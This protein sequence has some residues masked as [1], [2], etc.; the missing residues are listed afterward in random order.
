[1]ESGTQL[2]DEAEVTVRMARDYRF[3][4]GFNSFG[5]ARLVNRLLANNSLVS[6]FWPPWSDGNWPANTMETVS[7]I[8]AL[9]AQHLETWIPRCGVANK[10]NGIEKISGQKGLTGEL[11]KL[12]GRWERYLDEHH[13]LD[14]ATIQNRFLERQ[15]LMI[16][17]FQHVFVDEF[18]DSNPIQFAIHTRWLLNA[19][20]RVTVVGDDDQAIYRFRGSDIECFR[21]LEP[22]CKANSIRFRREDLTT[23]YR[24]TQAIVDFSQRFKSASSL[25]KLSMRKKIGPGPKAPKGK[26]VRLL[27]G[28]WQ[29]VCDAV[30]KE[31]VGFGLNKP[32][33]ATAPRESVAIL[34]FSTS[35]RESKS[36]KSPALALRKTL[37]AVGIRVYNPRNKMAGHSSSPVSMLLGL[38]SYLIDPVTFEP[39]GKNG[40]T[41]MV[42]ASH[43]D[44]A[45]AAVARSAPPTFR[46]NQKHINFQK[47]FLKGEGGDIGSPAP[48]RADIV[49]FL[50]RIRSALVKFPSGKRGRLTVAGLVS[51]LLTFPLFRNAGF[52]VDL[53][54][55]ALFTQLLEANIAP[56]RLT[57]KSLDQPLE[58]SEVKGKIVWDDRFW[59]FLN[60]F[61]AY[62]D[63]N[64]PDDLEVEAFE[65]GAVLMITFHQAKGLEFDHV[66]VAGAGREI[67]IAPALR[68]QLFSGERIP[69]KVGTNGVATSN[70]HTNQ[71]A[72][73][74]REREVYVAITRAK[75]SLT[76]LHDAVH[77]ELY[78]KMN[79]AIQA[80]FKGATEKRHNAQKSVT[81]MEAL[82]PAT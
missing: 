59:S 65:E 28:E 62:L 24:S 45:Y 79:P 25:S 75:Q 22:H 61:G 66:Y 40:R 27:K 5:P 50:D 80:V 21:G 26:P 13:I 11:V 47:K 52:T 74:D 20:T 10:P 42:W 82:C 63:N 67:D 15:S 41:V 36:W 54:R 34:S 58:A 72:A 44:V 7:F 30:A 14:F 51:R 70:A 38:I 73:G 35:E 49:Q 18:Q 37:E 46:I 29:N 68:T 64:S 43:S 33:D 60:H 8:C 17:R 1:M 69:F 16:A 6:L 9:L 4:L 39:V 81:V 23:N 12:Q 2:I 31:L 78:M 77:P 57:M 53:F 55:Q 32:P 3:A 71:L 76:I 56:T 19:P 48:N